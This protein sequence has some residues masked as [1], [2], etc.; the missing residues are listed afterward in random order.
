M[1]SIEGPILFNIKGENL[2][3]MDPRTGYSSTKGVRLNKNSKKTKK[4][5]NLSE[6]D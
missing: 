1:G 2:M 4:L 3:L 5:Y 6:N